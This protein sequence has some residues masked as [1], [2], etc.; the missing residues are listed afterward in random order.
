M[1]IWDSANHTAQLPRYFC[2]HATPFAQLSWAAK[3]GP[4]KWKSLEVFEPCS[5]RNH[6][7]L[8]WKQ[9]KLCV[10]LDCALI[11]DYQTWSCV[12][13][14][15]HAWTCAQ[16]H[17]HT[18]KESAHW[19]E[20]RTNFLVGAQIDNS[21]VHVQQSKRNHFSEQNFIHMY[22][23]QPTMHHKQT[24]KRH[25]NSSSH[26]HWFEAPQSCNNKSFPSV[27]EN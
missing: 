12:R 18:N 4:G 27:Q 1:D 8:N 11:L 20:I 16:T 21:L 15:P 2:S 17:R 24:M 19:A 13:S 22:S 25:P 6:M 3:A 14:E 26:V 7:K 10:T 5:C 9:V 23:I